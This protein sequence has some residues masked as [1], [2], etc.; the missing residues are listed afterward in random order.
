MKGD[1]TNL[2]TIGYWF[3][4]TFRR[5][6]RN[7]LLVAVLLALGGGAT[8]AAFA[9]ARRS[10]SSLDRFEAAVPSFDGAATAEDDEA[11]ERVLA[12]DGIA[13][14]HRF[15]LVGLMPADRPCGYEA[16]DFYPLAVS[17]SDPYRLDGVD[18]VH[19]RLPD[20]SAPHEV[21]L[22]VM[23][24]DRLG[25]GVGDTLRLGL[26]A[27]EP[28]CDGTSIPD[29]EQTFDLEVVGT[30][31][32]ATEIGAVESDFAVT[33]LT[34]AFG[35]R[36]P[37]LP[38]ISGAVALVEL[39][40]DADRAALAEAA[41]AHN[42]EIDFAF[43]VGPRVGSAVETIAA[44]LGLAGLVIGVATVVGVA[45]ALVRLAS[46]VGNDITTLRAL[47]VSRRGAMAAS[48]A[49]GVVAVVT[50]AIGAAVVAVALSPLHP[51]GVAR[52][53]ELDPGVDLDAPVI[54]LG[55]VALIALA[56]AAN[57]LAARM[58]VRRA[59]PRAQPSPSRRLSI[60]GLLN[61]RV[62][63]AAAIG[64][65]YALDDGRGDA[66]PG[67]TASIGAI[68][69]VSGLVAALVFATTLDATLH[70][71][72]RY[73]WGDFDATVG[74]P[75][76]GES[77]EEPDSEAIA[78]LL[79]EPGSAVA[80]VYERREV[81][82]DGAIVT[83]TFVQPLLGTAGFTVAA[84]RRPAGPG[85]IALGA[86]TAAALGID[87]GDTVTASTADDPTGV[88]VEVV[89]LAAF[90]ASQDSIPLATGFVADASLARSIGDDLECLEFEECGT[91]HYVTFGAGVS[92]AEGRR[93]LEAAGYEVNRPRPGAEVS[94][95]E[96][97]GPL[98]AALAALLG[99]LAIG[100]VLHALVS[101]PVRRRR[102]LATLRA[103]GFS[104]RQSR[105]VLLTE[106]LVIGLLG[107]VGGLVGGWLLG[108][109]G[110]QQVATTVGVP[111]T[112]HVPAIVLAAVVAGAVALGLLAAVPVAALAGRVTAA[113]ALRPNDND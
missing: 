112:P 105:V 18:V 7:A 96:A 17:E 68:I 91:G 104:R 16:S 30:T 84:G 14:H 83:G 15:F 47:G 81:R 19:G 49:L 77:G 103:I 97:V 3:R 89:G 2:A 37:D 56:G 36:H 106:G 57:A 94:R 85:E 4:T 26:P 101:T 72:A 41:A 109:L 35:R 22:P 52:Q 53:A 92:D 12:L 55:I 20:Q 88:A 80:E 28:E 39:E 107:G 95:L 100:G 5:R 87:V 31:R 11:L 10:G 99:V 60:S 61:L 108:R 71:P 23:I 98:P 59:A 42:G 93:R 78:R 50:G 33:P 58:V 63:P 69:G 1:T 29:W 74:L 111:A 51:I 76:D 44:S 21:A 73:G 48:G 62:P 79:T 46:L 40:P 90:A 43:L 32:R 54:G 34:V 38:D 24:A 70:D 65:S 67:R 113:R 102:E 9:G 27:G 25:L 45:L 75:N 110:W 6:A 82:L 64:T 8:L 66:V 13:A 86:E